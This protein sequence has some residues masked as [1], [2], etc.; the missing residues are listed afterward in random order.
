VALLANV[1]PVNPILVG[2]STGGLFAAQSYLAGAAADK[3]FLVNT[4]RRDGPRLKWIG[5]VL[6]RAV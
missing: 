1:N 3:L 5:D 4:L 6:V 2:L